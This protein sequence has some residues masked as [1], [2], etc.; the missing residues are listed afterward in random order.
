[1]TNRA[2]AQSWA[3]DAAIAQGGFDALHPQARGIIE[4][5]GVDHTDYD[6]VFGQVRSGAMMPKA[7]SSVAAQTEQRAGHYRATGFTAT[8]ADFY[9]RA[10]VLWAHAHYTIG[11]PADTRKAIFR[12]HVNDCVARLGDRVRRVVLDFDGGHLYGLLHL[13]AGEVRDAPAVILGPGMDMMKED[14]LLAARQYY[15]SN[16]IVA[17]SI[18]GPGQGESR[19]DG[20]PLD[21]TN[22]ERALSRFIDHLTALPEVDADRIGMFGISMSGYW[23]HRLAATDRRLRALA[24]FE[25]VT[26]DFATIFERAQPSFKANF[27]R[28]AGYTGEAAF[29]R[30]L[31]ARLPLGDLVTEISCPVLVGVG[32]FDEL[33]QLDQVLAT[34]EKMTAPKEIRVYED[35]F[36]PLGGVAAEVLRFGADWLARALD[37]ELAEPGRDA[38]H[39]VRRDGTITSG[40][41]DPTWWLGG[42]TAALAA[43]RAR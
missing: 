7:W 14:Y 2:T 11:D 10:A 34:Y 22:P 3:L 26:G 21:L 19:V 12:R 5:F 42:T 30:D 20:V 13:P 38:R 18:D 8:A 32:E 36:H 40:S 9:Q 28:M 29:D 39:Y 23:G 27:M 1:M 6:K 33:S 24:S 15:T 16:G 31:A 4:A 35:E 17:L 41:A 25:G 37:G 43:A